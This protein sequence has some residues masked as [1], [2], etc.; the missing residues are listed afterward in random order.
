MSKVDSGCIN[1]LIICNS[2][3]SIFLNQIKG[4]EN[5]SLEFGL[6]IF[7]YIENKLLNFP[8]VGGPTMAASLR[9][10]VYLYDI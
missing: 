5:H 1:P 7:Q 4:A 9:Y 8:L 3:F 10:F 2:I 6:N